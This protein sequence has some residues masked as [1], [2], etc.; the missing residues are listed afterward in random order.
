[1]L[2][3][4]YAYMTILSRQRAKYEETTLN[5]TTCWQNRAI[6]DYFT[7]L[8]ILQYAATRHSGMAEIILTAPKDRGHVTETILVFVW[9]GLPLKVRYVIIAM[10]FASKNSS[11]NNITEA[12]NFYP[13]SFIQS[14]SSFFSACQDYST[15]GQCLDRSDVKICGTACN[16]NDPHLFRYV[17]P[18]HKRLTQ[19]VQI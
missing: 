9:T 1:M 11:A 7:T 3:Y 4:H 17:I 16:Q 2:S 14:S 13:V 12:Y 6:L 5:Y 10:D 15:I 19:I 18:G 8:N